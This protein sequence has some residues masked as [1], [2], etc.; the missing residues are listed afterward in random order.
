MS[1]TGYHRRQSTAAMLVCLW[2]IGAALCSCT[3]QPAPEPPAP[4][5]PTATPTAPVIDPAATG[6]E[7]LLFSSDRAGNGDIYV[8][9][10]GRPP[11]NLTDHPAGDWDATWSPACADPTATCRIAFTS[12]RSGDSEIWV[13]DSTG[14]NLI[15]VTQHPAWDYW[16]AWSPDGTQV[17]F[18]S[19]RDGDQ[20]LFIQP[21]GGGPATQITFNADS[22]RLP[23]W[24]PDGRLIAFA[25]VRNDSEAIHLINP[26]GSFERPLTRWPLKATAPAWLPDGQRIA[27]IGWD[28]ENRPG[29]YIQELSSRTARRVWEG[30][31]WIGSL[32]WSPGSAPDGV[33]S[34]LLFTA[35]HAGNH[36]LFA[37]APGGGSEPV[38][39]T[40]H[41]AWDDFAELRAGLAL[42]PDGWLV[43]ESHLALDTVPASAPPESVSGEFA[44]GFNIADLSK[45]YLTR[46]LGLHWAKG[47]VNWETVEP[48]RGRY[49]WGDPDNTVSVF[50]GQQLRVL[51]R[52]HGTPAWARPADTSLTHP[53]DDMA[54]FGSFV[55]EL[56][57]R[58]QGQVAAYEIWNEPNLNYEWGYLPPDPARYTEMLITAYRAIKSVDPDVLVIG[59]GL[60]TTGDG[61]PTA[62]GDLDFLRGMYASGARGY[63]DA[64][65]SHPYAYGHD[66]DYQDM[67]GLSLSRVAEQ[68]E[69]MLA[70]GDGATPV[71]ITELGWV[72]R[73]SWNL[74]EHER[75]S[76]SEL[77]QAQYLV[78]AY[79]KIRSEWPWV[80]GLFVFNLDFSVVPW[81]TAAEPMR[82]YA[83]LNPDRTPRPAYTAIKHQMSNTK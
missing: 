50:G 51:L 54:D 56:A 15:N 42:R 30:D 52:I 45:A 21:V 49:R 43:E 13:M 9:A 64:L 47:Y 65:G 62:L 18:V 8:A 79:D 57:R 67:W 83:V 6:Q 55:A 34:W 71:W 61:S 73:S 63:F 80:H 10:P 48:K 20:E 23:A 35:W 19:E 17:A 33:D 60:A 70:N 12:H 31:T 37:L 40:H 1:Q 29:V 3:P 4:I 14:R 27:F 16:P 11:V 76:V 25:A 41:P 74:D 22:D 72:L 78:R 36:E 75:I 26:D 77:Q 24:S 68:R 69:V 39:L 58:Y 59:G 38:R 66:P 2:L 46:D 7:V 32:S 81:Y 53:P 5:V 82:W 28:Q 44:Y